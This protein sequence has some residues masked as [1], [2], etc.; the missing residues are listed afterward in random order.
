MMMVRQRYL[1]AGEGE[2]I[3]T[4]DEVLECVRHEVSLIIGTRGRGHQARNG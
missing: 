4:L 2:Q 1:D 3:P